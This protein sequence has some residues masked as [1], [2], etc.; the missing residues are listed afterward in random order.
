[1]STRAMPG[2]SGS[3]T[4]LMQKFGIIKLQFNLTITQII[5]W[6]IVFKMLTAA[7]IVR[8]TFCNQRV[9]AIKLI[10]RLVEQYN[11]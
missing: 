6:F 7:A 2:N 10:Q 5:I 1:M 9:E 4:S 11:K 3:N 8:A